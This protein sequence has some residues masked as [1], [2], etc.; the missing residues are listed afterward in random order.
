MK[1]LLIVDDE[2]AIVEALEDILSLEGYD[3][4]TAYNGDEGLQR[5]LASKPDLVLLDLM[6]PV[7]DGGELLRRI[8]AHPDLC[9]LPVVVMSAG[10]LTDEERRA[11]SHFL[12]KPFELDDLLGTLA[13]Q[14]PEDGPRA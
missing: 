8:R 1:R 11:S 10:R 14:L 5:L 3:I 13:K 12:A 9:D 6:M 2:F 7:M 4:V